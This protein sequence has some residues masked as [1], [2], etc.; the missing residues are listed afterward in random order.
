MNHT[1]LPSKKSDKNVIIK[2]FL[3]MVPDRGLSWQT[4]IIAC[5]SLSVA[6]AYFPREKD[7]IYPAITDYII[8]NIASH[9]TQIQSDSKTTHKVLHGAN[10]FFN[11]VYDH[12]A[13]LLSILLTHNPALFMKLLWDVSDEIWHIAGDT[14]TDY[15]YYSK[16][17]LLSKTLLNGVNFL[18]G[19]GDDIASF[20]K[21]DVQ[22]LFTVIKP[23][24]QLTKR[25][26][27]QS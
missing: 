16:R 14:S 26:F 9:T 20:L 24:M 6:L 1:P 19:G 13:K 18:I 15:N 23:V 21:R 12:D 7:D 2:T 10:I 11:T 4:M 27:G 17:V 8:N 22:R 3:E 5:G 25:L